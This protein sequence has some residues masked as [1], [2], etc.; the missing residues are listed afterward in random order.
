[1]ERTL[2]DGTR[3]AEVITKIR[4]LL[5][6]TTVEMAP[7]NIN[8]AIQEVVALARPEVRKNEV[9]LR[10]DLDP[11]LPSVTGDRVLLHK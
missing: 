4:S 9:K 1:M 3:A 7:V 5:R 11:A 2:R 6:K 10:V 8:D